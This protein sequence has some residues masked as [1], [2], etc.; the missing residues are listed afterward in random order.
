[1]EFKMMNLCYGTVINKWKLSR[2]RQAK[3]PHPQH[4]MQFPRKAAS[5]H[6]TSKMSNRR[7]QRTTMRILKEVTFLVERKFC[8]I[9]S[10]FPPPQFFCFSVKN[11]HQK[12][13]FSQFCRGQKRRVEKWGGWRKEWKR[14]NVSH[15]V[16]QW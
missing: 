15:F 4:S 2:I 13:A 1:M 11:L 14:V 8:E 16:L 7:S 12:I 6:Y 5:S 3:F 9:P 10:P